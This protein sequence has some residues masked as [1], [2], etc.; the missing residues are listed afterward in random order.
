M[1]ALLCHCRSTFPSQS[2]VHASCHG[3][4]AVPW[5]AHFFASYLAMNNVEDEIF[6]L[7]DNSLDSSS[8]V[9]GIQTLRQLYRSHGNQL[10]IADIPGLF[11]RITQRLKD[12]S[13]S[14]IYAAL[15]FLADIS[16]DYNSPEV[17]AQMVAV[18]SPVI[19]ALEHPKSMIR[20]AA[21]QVVVQL[22]RKSNNRQVLLDNLIQYGLNGTSWKIRKETCDC[23]SMA[24]EQ[25]TNPKDEQPS[26]WED[27]DLQRIVESLMEKLQDSSANVIHATVVALSRIVRKVGDEKLEKWIDSFDESLREGYTQHIAKIQRL[28]AA[29]PAGIL[30]AKSIDFNRLHSSGPGEDLGFGCIPLEI[31]DQ[32]QNKNDWRIRATGIENLQRV[33]SD[34]ED[35]TDLAPHLN[36]FCAFLSQLLEDNNFKICLVSLHILEDIVCK[37]G[38]VVRAGLPSLVSPLL[39]KMADPKSIIRQSSARIFQHLMRIL[40]PRPIL[41]ISLLSLAHDNYRVREELGNLIIIALLN[42]PQHAFDFPLLLSNLVFL[43]QDPRARVRYVSLEACAVVARIIGNSQCLDII[44]EYCQN[45]DIVQQVNQRLHNPLIPSVSPE[46]IVEHLLSRGSSG[47]RTSSALSSDLSWSSEASGFTNYFSKSPPSLT[48]SPSTHNSG[49][50]RTPPKYPKTNPAVIAPPLEILADKVGDPQKAKGEKKHMQRAS[51]DKGA[52][53]VKQAEALPQIGQSAIP[54]QHPEQHPKEIHDKNNSTK[55]PSIAA[56]TN[57]RTKKVPDHCEPSVIKAQGQALRITPTRNFS[58]DSLDTAHISSASPP[59]QNNVPKLRGNKTHESSSNSKRI[60][61]TKNTTTS[62]SEESVKGSK[63]SMESVKNDGHKANRR[64]RASH[65]AATISNPQDVELSDSPDFDFNNS[66]DQLRQTADWDK[67]MKALDTLNALLQHGSSE[68]V[69]PLFASNLHDLCVIVSDEIGNLRTQVMRSAVSLMTNIYTNMGKHLCTGGP[70]L[71][72]TV[73]ALFKKL[74]EGS[75]RDTFLT[76][77]VGAALEALCQTQGRISPWRTILAVM[78]NYDHKNAQVR[79]RVAQCIYMIMKGAPDSS[80]FLH[81]ALSSPLDA[82][83]LIPVLVKYTGDG[84]ADT[85]NVAKNMLLEMERRIPDL[86]AVLERVASNKDISAVKE[87]LENAR[88]N[89]K[90]NSVGTELAAPTLTLQSRKAS[91]VILFIQ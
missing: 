72:L 57:T 12:N 76:E 36:E 73:S 28:S 42:H 38:L 82:Q 30:P 59:L 20:C 24:L 50:K 10:L 75:G 2:T 51:I 25:P 56:Q 67:K 86:L 55:L 9:Q 70:D 27:P 81:K 90:L 49:P 60:P 89:A 29:Q 19:G 64:Q 26:P 91:K 52:S 39:A 74:G 15:L 32:L 84:L 88:K 13:N 7:L 40:S 45:E 37:M 80:M 5:C 62:A 66:I 58:G 21:C 79:S 34:L 4:L 11:Y 3:A 68:S 6:H 16:P 83:K 23:V 61:E 1:Y 35:V 17:N 54:K 31:L 77:E 65:V 46:G 53:R 87:I 8:R 22:L 44:R 43:A 85:R 33:V 41:D 47:A 18:V 48:M 63:G 14:A 78:N 69:I 71:E